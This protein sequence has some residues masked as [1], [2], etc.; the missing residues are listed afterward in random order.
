MATRKS[1]ARSSRK[2]EIPLSARLLEKDISAD[3]VEKLTTD[4]RRIRNT[5][6]EMKKTG[7][8]AL[9]VSE[10][11]GFPDKEKTVRI[12]Y[13][14]LYTARV[15]EK[16]TKEL[17]IMC[18][19]KGIG[20]LIDYLKTPAF[21]GSPNH[22][23]FL[24]LAW[25]QCR[26][27][28]DSGFKERYEV[29]SEALKMVAGRYDIKVKS[30]EKIEKTDAE[31]DDIKKVEPEL[32]ELPKLISAEE[33]KE[34]LDNFMGRGMGDE[35]S[36]LLKI[37]EEIYMEK[38]ENY[39]VFSDKEDLKPLEMLTAFF[40]GPGKRTLSLDAGYALLIYPS[41]SH[42]YIQFIDTSRR[43][44][45][46]TTLYSMHEEKSGWDNFKYA[47]KAALDE[48]KKIPKKDRKTFYVYDTDRLSREDITKW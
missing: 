33:A 14:V 17:E 46:K 24:K 5:L 18:D 19:E 34:V 47:L 10:K 35:L 31:V 45:V 41:G 40:G 38:R 36:N 11:N 37:P 30:Y 3:K 6:P 9:Y 13:A 42:T 4:F 2:K 20:E 32:A 26:S 8:N 1:T 15:L 39:L 22:S 28:D 44:A 16:L 25:E 21:S 43:V 27:G 12:A 48:A 23:G 7:N 29:I